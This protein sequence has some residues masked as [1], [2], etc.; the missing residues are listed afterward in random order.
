[1]DHIASTLGLSL[2]STSARSAVMQ[3]TK[4]TVQAVSSS[5]AGDSFLCF[6]CKESSRLDDDTASLSSGDSSSFSNSVSF[7][8]PLVTS[9]FERPKTTQ[10]EKHHLYYTELEYREFRNDCLRGREPRER[11]VKFDPKIVS[12]VHTYS[13]AVNKDILFYSDSDL[14]K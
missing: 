6:D 5:S 3:E 12:K 1:M 13:I 4:I 8:T 7:A 9:V 11:I 14:Q 10:D 2:P